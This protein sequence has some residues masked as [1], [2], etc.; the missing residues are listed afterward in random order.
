M[1]FSRGPGLSLIRPLSKMS[2]I[3]Y[4][5]T[6]SI[7]RIFLKLNDWGD[8]NTMPQPENSKETRPRQGGGVDGSSL[9]KC[10]HVW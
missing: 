3:D 1:R 5:I 10:V 6:F 8:V 9:I 2:L 7:S 4:I